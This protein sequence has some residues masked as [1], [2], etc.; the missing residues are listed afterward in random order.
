MRKPRL[1]FP[2]LCHAA[3]SAACLLALVGFAAGC[4]KQSRSGPDR[5]AE[6]QRLY[7]RADLMVR[8][9]S[10][11]EYSYDYINFH[12]QQAM[13]NIDR[14]LLEYPDT[15][16]GQKV[17]HDEL[18]LGP[19]A[20][21]YFRNDLLAQLGDMKE[22][23]ESVVN[24]AIY[25]YDLPEANPA[26]SHVALA[27][28]LE[29][30]CKLVRSDEAMI[31]P[32]QPQ[33]DL[34][35]KETIVRIDSEYQ[36]HD[37]ALSIL[38]GADSSVQPPLAAAYGEGLAIGGTKLSALGDLS[39]Q[40]PTPN[41]Q[42]ELGILR[43]MV[44]REE[45]TY[46]NQFD[47]V[48]QKQEKDAREAEEALAKSGKKPEKPKEAAV[49]YDVAAYYREKFGDHPPAEAL[50]VFAGLQALEGRLDEARALV[51][52]LNESA[53]VTVIQ[54]HYEHLAL[55]NQLT[56][57]EDLPR[58]LGLSEDGQA[59]CELKLVE[60]LAANARYAAADALEKT[61]MQ[62]FPKFRDQ[63][64]CSRMHGV[65]YSREELFTLDAETIAHLDIKDPAVAA[66]VLLDWFLSPNRLPTKSWGADQIVF[67][68]FSMGKEGRAVSHKPKKDEKDES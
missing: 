2:F 53:L 24:C 12:Y 9:I 5:E 61:G 40:Y 4:A 43:G 33:D 63:F 20:I 32:V 23:T 28:I 59:H 48:R 54:N 45:I 49:R 36:Q 41:K 1:P 25:L 65:F 18:K 62:E 16:Y 22:A 52:H 68:Y 50:A 13:K 58:Q 17:Q 7:E 21:P 6:A 42:V 39:D 26:E 27:Q 55:L 19:Y 47:K 37:L 51:A 10:E 35:A 57:S 46:R 31:F 64:I 30:L 14:I 29:T 60:L 56:G 66:E 38:E 11:G 44:E 15:V 3:L 8:K 67:K 34:Y